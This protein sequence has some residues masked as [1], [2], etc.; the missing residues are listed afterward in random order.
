MEID[1]ATSQPYPAPTKSTTT[2]VCSIPTEI[3]VISFS[4]KLFLTVSQHGRLAH[5]VRSQIY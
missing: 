3:T 1:G 2:V 4:D 5:W